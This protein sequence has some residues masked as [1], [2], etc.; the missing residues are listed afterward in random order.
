[1]NMIA[2]TGLSRSP[3]KSREE[4]TETGI[5]KETV[6]TR[7]DAQNLAHQ[8]ATTTNRD[9]QNAQDL[10]AE[11]DTQN[12]AN[13]TETD[14]A[15][16]SDVRGENMIMTTAEATEDIRRKFNQVIL[17]QQKS[18]H[19]SPHQQIVSTIIQITQ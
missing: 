14:H 18:N 4:S 10:T 16:R 8:D 12:P 11:K 9:T 5:T 13:I 2:P 19:N 3:N 17:N 6:V 15:Q 1:M 7:E